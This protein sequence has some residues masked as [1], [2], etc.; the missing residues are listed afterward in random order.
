MEIEPRDFVKILSR[1]WQ[2]DPH[3]L[4]DFA[5]SYIRKNEFMHLDRGRLYKKRIENYV[6]IHKDTKITRMQILTTFKGAFI[7][8]VEAFGERGD[9]QKCIQ[10][11]V[12]EGV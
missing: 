6:Y 9:E 10:K 7:K 1:F 11:R 12:G 5:F 4:I 8:D 2:F 3:F